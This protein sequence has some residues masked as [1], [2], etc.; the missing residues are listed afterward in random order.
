LKFSFQILVFFSDFRKKDL[1]SRKKISAEKFRNQLLK[2]SKKLKIGQKML[3]HDRIKY[4]N[5]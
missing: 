3:N 5:I 2:N 4:K 1:K